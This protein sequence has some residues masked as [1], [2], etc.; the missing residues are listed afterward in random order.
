MALPMNIPQAPGLVLQEQF[1]ALDSKQALDRKQPAETETLGSGSESIDSSKSTNGKSLLS[2]GAAVATSL[3]VESI[4][5]LDAVADEGGPDVIEA[6]SRAPSWL[7]P[8]VLVFPPLSYFLFNVY[9]DKVSPQFLLIREQSP[10]PF[11]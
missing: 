11:Y 4:W 8:A 2:L 9:R 7:V 5:L 3:A 10:L 6:V 1:E